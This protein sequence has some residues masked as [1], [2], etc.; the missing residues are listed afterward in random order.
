M[1]R[2]A[3]LPALPTTLCLLRIDLNLLIST[4][5]P[6]RHTSLTGAPGLRRSRVGRVRSF[7]LRSAKSVVTPEYQSACGTRSCGIVAMAGFSDA[8]RIVLALLLMMLKEVVFAAMDSNTG[9]ELNVVFCISAVD[10][11]IYH[12]N[13]VFL[14]AIHIIDNYIQ[15]KNLSEFKHFLNFLPL[16]QSIFFRNIHKP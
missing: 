16:N 11:V 6:H 12:G 3:S 1:W 14:V 13:T 15:T 4:H 10:I 5:I 7:S 2:H 9:K 8:H